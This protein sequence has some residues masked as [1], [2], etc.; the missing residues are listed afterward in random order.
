MNVKNVGVFI[1]VV[2]RL[3]GECSTKGESCIILRVNIIFDFTELETNLSD[4]VLSG[5]ATVHVLMFPI[6]GN[7]LFHS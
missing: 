1:S 2:I 6:F 3:T 7:A 4:I 5:V